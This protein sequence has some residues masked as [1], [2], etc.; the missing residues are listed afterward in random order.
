MSS[1]SLKVSGLIIGGRK[2]GTTWLYENFQNDPEFCVSK[3]VKESGY[4]SGG[5][6]VDR[7]N[8]EALYEDGIDARKIEV[9]TSICYS[10]EAATKILDY[11]PKMLIVLILREPAAY[12][13]SRYT[14]SLRKGELHEADPLAALENNKWLRDELNYPKIISR[15]KA[16]EIGNQL[17]VLPFSFLNQNPIAFYGNVKAALGG[18]PYGNFTPSLLPVNVAR[19]A[20]FAWVSR[21]LS[22][23][24]KMSRGI[25]A[26]QMV[27]AV[28]STGVLKLLEKPAVAPNYSM[29]IL[30]AAIERAN[31]GTDA[32]YRKICAD[33]TMIDW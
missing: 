10:P 20:R 3:K 21:L 24:A 33:A 7:T 29:E 30:N 2:C 17:T 8:Y 1:H 19:N 26:H 32:A 5:S 25:G 6:L 4:F 16:F 31:P 13:I 18:N 14:H 9:D 27:N 23:G 15:F 28:K 11:N 22:S 12:L